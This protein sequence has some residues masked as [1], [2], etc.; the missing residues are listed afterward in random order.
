MK[1]LVELWE[2]KKS[3]YE[4][5]KTKYKTFPY[6]TSS[7]FINSFLD[8]SITVLSLVLVCKITDEGAD[9]MTGY[10]QARNVVAVAHKK[11]LLYS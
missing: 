1:V 11:S 8:H 6:A 10:F 2:K 3:F 9:R 5:N 4:K 7:A